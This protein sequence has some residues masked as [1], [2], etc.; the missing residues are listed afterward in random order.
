MSVCWLASSSTPTLH[1]RQA[2]ACCNQSVRH[3]RRWA[4]AGLDNSLVGSCDRAE[5]M[6]LGG[7]EGDKAEQSHALLVPSAW[8]LALVMRFSPAWP[9]VRVA[10]DPSRWIGLSPSPHDSR[11]P[12]HVKSAQCTISHNITKCETFWRAFRR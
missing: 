10:Y 3:L 6:S 5:A 2:V 9:Y 8:L 7:Q 11:T 4:L 12:K 1:S